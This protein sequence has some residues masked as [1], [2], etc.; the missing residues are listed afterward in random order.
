MEGKDIQEE[1]EIFKNKNNEDY[2]KYDITKSTAIQ[3]IK[4]ARK[5]SQRQNSSGKLA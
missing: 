4:L 1:E 3:E 5:K 2:Q